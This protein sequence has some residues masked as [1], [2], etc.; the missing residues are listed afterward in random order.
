MLMTLYCL[1]IKIKWKIFWNCLIRDRR[2]TVDFGDENGINFL[3]IK[4]MKQEGKIIFDINQ[5]INN[6]KPTNSGRYLNYYSNY[7]I[8]YKKDVIIEQL[9]RILL[10]SHPKFH[11]KN[12]SNLIHTPLINDHP[13]EFNNQ[14]FSIIKN[15]IKTLENRI[16]LDNNNDCNNKDNDSIRCVSLNPLFAHRWH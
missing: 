11:E 16:N 8:V 7:L 2:F 3:D 9:D 13:L 10:L 15:R 12:I 1:R 5:L 4:L 14:I 6:K